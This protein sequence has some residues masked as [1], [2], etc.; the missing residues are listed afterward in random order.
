MKIVI[1]SLLLLF[2]IIQVRGHAALL[3]PPARNVM[4]RTGFTEVPY[5]PDD[6]YLV[7]TEAEGGTTKCPPC[8][9]R[10]D[11]PLPHPHEAGGEFAKGIITRTYNM[12]QVM[13]VFVNVTRSHG[14]F[15]E[16]KICPNNNISVP[17]SQDC[18]D[19]YPLQ[20]L[21]Q[22]SSKVKLKAPY[23]GTEEVKVKVK[24]P[25]SLTCSQCV[26]QMSTVG[27]QYLPTLVMFRNCADVAING[28]KRKSF[29]NSFKRYKVF[30]R[31]KDSDFGG[32]SF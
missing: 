32:K 20:I 27:D 22:Q 16:F 26:L 2:Q 19:Q 10:D 12:G 23:D 14:G 13:E 7:C 15:I 1:S 11:T 17:V 9:D 3:E 8:G 6:D 5:H 28:R 21:G 25:S 18:L 30:S 24:L 29:V 4:W 31:K